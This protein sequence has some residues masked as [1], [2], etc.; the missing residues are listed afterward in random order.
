[1]PLF[2]S[3]R[4]PDLSETMDSPICDPARLR[5]TYRQFPRVNALISGSESVYKLWIRPAMVDRNMGYSLLDIGFGGGDIAM[6]MARWAQRDGYRLEVTGIEID[7]RAYDYVKTL[8][9]PD[10][11]SFHHL[12]AA[13]LVAA[14]RTFDFVVSN[15]LL[16]H[17]DETSLCTA[18]AYARRLANRCALFVDI[19][20][21]DIAYALFS[22]MTLAG[23]RNSYIRCDGL[24]SIRRSYTRRELAE[25]APPDWKVESL[26]PFPLLLVYCGGE[27]AKP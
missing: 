15:H 27:G 1:M 4:N 20:R 3:R 17:L 25:V 18:L 11:V 6:N 5:N 21:S 24:V 14:G 8:D 7:Q 12:D 2:L 26:F 10:N 19:R 9:W 22:A 13:E 16:H 23:F